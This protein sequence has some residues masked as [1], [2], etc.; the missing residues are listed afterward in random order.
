MKEYPPE[1]MVWKGIEKKLN[2]RINVNSIGL[3]TRFDP[4][5]SVWNT[6]GE[7]LSLRELTGKLNAFEPPETIW[8]NIEKNQAK[9]LARHT[10]RTIS[11]WVRWSIAAAA[12]IAGVLFVYFFQRTSGTRIYILG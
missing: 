5:E 10:G 3:L 6:I 2:S 1:E 4:P 11:M 12:M 8:L 7:E 9:K